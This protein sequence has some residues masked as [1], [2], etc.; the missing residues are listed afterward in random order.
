MKEILIISCLFLNKQVVNVTAIFSTKKIK[1]TPRNTADAVGWTNVLS[2][3]LAQAPA[4]GRLPNVTFALAAS[5]V[6]ADREHRVRNAVRWDLCKPP[7]KHRKDEH[8][9]GRLQQRPR[10]L[11]VR[12]VDSP[13]A[14]REEF[15]RGRRRHATRVRPVSR[16]Q[17]AD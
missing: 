8:H 3:T 16:Q 17:I 12:F 2:G 14:G 1:K 10:K 5:Q 4:T 11:R 7:E 6:R 15:A 9:H 13:T